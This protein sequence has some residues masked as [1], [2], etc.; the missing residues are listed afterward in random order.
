MRAADKKSTQHRKHNKL[1]N[2]I[3][4][5]ESSM[6]PAQISIQRLNEAREMVTTTEQRHISLAE[7]KRRFTSS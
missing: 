5:R 2:E 7:T 6:G 4:P 3:M 1:G